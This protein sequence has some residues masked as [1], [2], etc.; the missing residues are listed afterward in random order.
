[1]DDMKLEKKQNTHRNIL[2]FTSERPVAINLRHV[3]SIRR[4]G[5]TIFF[6]FSTKTQ[7]IDFD[8]EDAA[9]SV[10]ETLMNIWSG[11]DLE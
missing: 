7:P 6:D 5:K 8:N 11:D 1:M 10:F 4:E 2:H 3:S 9:K